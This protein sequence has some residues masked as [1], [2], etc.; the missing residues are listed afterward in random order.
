[1]RRHGALS[2]NLELDVAFHDTDLMQVV[3]HGHYLKYLENARW[4]LMDDIGFGY[5]TMVASGYS[6][7]IIDVHVRYVRIAKFGDRLNVRASLVEWESR[8][9]VNYL[10]TDARTGARVARARTLQAAVHVQTHEMQLLLPQAFTER[11]NV[12]FAAAADERGDG[13]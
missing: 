11:V 1:M 3:W 10:V 7:P 12:R 9:G 5:E 6:W 13:R 8:L 4:K 2:V